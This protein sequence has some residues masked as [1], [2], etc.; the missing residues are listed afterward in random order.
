MNLRK[1]AKI[2]ALSLTLVLIFSSTVMA[3]STPAAPDTPQAKNISEHRGHKVMHGDSGYKRLLDELKISK[4]DIDAARSSQKTL[5][6]LAK[7][8]GYTPQQVKDKLLK[9][10]T[11]AVNKAV[12]E[13]KLTKEMASDI[14]TKKKE[15]LA[16]WDGSFKNFDHRPKD[17]KFLRD[18]GLSKQ[19]IEEA[20]KSGKTIFDLAKEKKNLTPQQ[21]KDM[22]IKDK[23][24]A[25]NK[26]VSDGE[27]TKE[28]GEQIITNMK[29][30]IQNWDGKFKN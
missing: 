4:E 17:I 5:F 9:Y 23:A 1:T 2:T 12:T 13:G 15:R 10:E 18:L 14:L 24:E 7:E 29:T 28:K 26:K 25:I 11:E 3:S 30:R 22:M 6:D 21:V 27:L 8:K 20:R 16:A 19:E